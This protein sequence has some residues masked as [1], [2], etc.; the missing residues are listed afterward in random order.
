M[1][2]LAETLTSLGLLTLAFPLWRLRREYRGTALAGVWGWWAAGWLGL[3][4]VRVMT[5]LLDVPGGAASLAWY[6]A[7]ILALAPGIAVLGARW[8]NCRV[9]NFFVVAPLLLVFA[10]PAAAAL[11]RGSRL[12]HWVL[13][14]PMVVGYLFVLVMGT[15]NF[16]ATRHTLPALCAACAWAL[17]V[18]SLCP[19]TTVPVVSAESARSLCAILIT[20]AG[21]AAAIPRGRLPPAPDRPAILAAWAEF[22]D[23]F[24][25]V[26]GRRVQDRWNDELHRAG[27]PWRI[28]WH[29]LESPAGTHRETPEATPDELALAAERLRWILQKFVNPDWVS[30]R[31]LS[32]RET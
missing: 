27:I 1:K 2:S 9:W 28:G 10:W 29:G 13:E 16:L 4:I 21:W 20:A 3:V 14:E 24:G 18:L 26:W 32:D 7:S 25:S 11:V 8:P 5:T 30:R 22:R 12:E 15:G 19:L 17:V 6:L 31:I 23:L